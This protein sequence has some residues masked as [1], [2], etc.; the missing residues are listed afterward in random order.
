MLRPGLET[1]ETRGTRRK[2]SGDAFPGIEKLR[3]RGPAESEKV[4]SWAATARFNSTPMKIGI[5]KC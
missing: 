1:R 4:A 2:K 3:E 5:A